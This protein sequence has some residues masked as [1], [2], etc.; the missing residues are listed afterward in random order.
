MKY[1]TRITELLGIDLPVI[2]AP[3]FLISYPELVSA[4]SEAGGL[5]TFPALNYRS[6]EKLIEGIEE[7]KKLTSK[8]FGVNLV[9]HKEHNPEWQKQFEICLQYKVPVL[10]TSMGTPRSIIKEARAEGVKVLCDVTNIRQANLLAKIGADAIIAVCQG[11][12]GHAGNISPMSLIPQIK[13]ET[14]L[15][16]IGAGAISDG[17]QMAAAFCLGA[18]AV[19]VGTRFIA[20]PES[21]ARDNYKQAILDSGSEDIVYLDS[22]SGHPANWIKKS[23]EGLENMPK[24]K[25]STVKKSWIDVWSAGHGV[26]Q[27]KEIIPARDIVE[28]MMLEF[29]KTLHDL[30]TSI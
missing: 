22:V 6:L 9:L 11:A 20:T 19:Y 21:R 27:I 16:V 29:R 13:K 15:P 1:P 17:K 12:G 28:N 23:L 30:K 25:M 18:D 5:G 2:G 3:M 10:I 8:P 14:G 26:S 7:I 4:V 24:E